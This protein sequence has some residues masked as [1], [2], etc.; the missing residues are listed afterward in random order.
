MKALQGSGRL[1]N[2][3]ILPGLVIAALGVL[4]LLHN[5]DV[6]NI[7][8]FYKLWPM[9][10]IAL[11]L[12]WAI[13]GRNKVFGALVVVAGAAL[14]LDTLGWV[15]VEW[16]EIWRFWPLLLVAVGVGMM[17]QKGGRDNVFGGALIASLGAY[18]LA[19]NFHLIRF[20]LWELWPLAVI[21][22]GLAMIRK[23]WR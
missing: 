7:G 9:L 22:L 6:V 2:P 13:E 11:G 10:M 15:D 4:L 1:A 21:L 5:F 17:V 12:Q 19:S 14:Q 8:S 23:A 16:R 20:D 3:R 18:F